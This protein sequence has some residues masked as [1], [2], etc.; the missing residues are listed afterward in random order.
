ML[1]VKKPDQGLKASIVESMTTRFPERCF[2]TEGTP[3]KELNHG[4][5]LKFVVF[6][7]LPLISK[8]LYI[9][10]DPRYETNI[11]LILATGNW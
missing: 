1:I 2:I 6:I 8:Y 7:Y 4:H 11:W 9:N 5:L 10:L 3:K